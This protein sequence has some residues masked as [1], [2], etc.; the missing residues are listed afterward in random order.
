MSKN[1]QENKSDVL[2]YVM[3]L[4]LAFAPILATKI[5]PVIDFY[6]HVSRYYILSTIDKVAF[7]Q[8]NYI[9][10]WSILPNIGMDVIG[11]VVLRFCNPLISA[12]IL[13]LFIF[14]VQYSGVLYFNKQITGHYSRLT[15]ILMVPLLYSFIFIWGFANFLLAIGV[16]FWAAGM[17][18]SEPQSSKRRVVIACFFGVLIFLCHGLAFVLYGI[19]IFSIELGHFL[20]KRNFSSTAIQNSLI[21]LI[22][23][24]VTPVILFFS[25]K[26]ANPGIGVNHNHNTIADLMHTGGLGQE[27]IKITLYRLQTIVRVSESPSFWFDLL[28][29]TLAAGLLIGLMLRRQLFIRKLMWPALIA[30][31]VLVIVTPSN[32]FG[33]GYVSDRMPLFAAF[34][35]IGSL[36]FS[37]RNTA[38]R[39]SCMTLLG[40]SAVLRLIYL[41]ISWQPYNTYFDEF[42]SVAALIP[43]RSLVAEVNVRVSGHFTS[44]PQC[45]MYGPLLISL[46]GHVGPIFAISS[47]QPV[48]LNGRLAYAVAHTTSISALKD[49]DMPETFNRYI[50][51][52]SKL[53]L[54]DYLLIC[55]EKMLP[56]PLPTDAVVMAKTSQ[57]TL[58][59]LRAPGFP[60]QAGIPVP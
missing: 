30:S 42:K 19:L 53:S 16:V 17:W 27:L 60:R 34:L 25:S 46:Y 22:I 58:L 11:A 55:N 28:T 33:V 43:P 7:L 18:I 6:N 59:K 15:A 56:H 57:F 21:S 41:T 4:V 14:T 13:L 29:L 12:K 31:A 10:N 40:I 44:S 45:D 35:C 9:S 23:P 37:I 52:A 26:T 32:L 48:K 36:N 5:I 39:T 54:F 38:F 47:Q 2:F 3:V 20:E 8:A 49:E 51:E 50:V 24:A 1:N